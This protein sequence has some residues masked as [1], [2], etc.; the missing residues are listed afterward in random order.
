[1]HV[2]VMGSCEYTTH[3]YFLVFV[4]I[5]T[6]SHTHIRTYLLKEGQWNFSGGEHPSH[7]GG[8]MT[9]PGDTKFPSCGQICVVA[10]STGGGVGNRGD[11]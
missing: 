9:S 11:V 8:E 4:Y 1:M 6:H 2:G 10:V 7:G 5:C 3:T